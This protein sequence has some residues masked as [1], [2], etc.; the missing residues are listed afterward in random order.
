MRGGRASQRKRQVHVLSGLKEGF[1]PETLSQRGFVTC[2]LPK[3]TW[4]I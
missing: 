3:M 2:F 4:L 1:G